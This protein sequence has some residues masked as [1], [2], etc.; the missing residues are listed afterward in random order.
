MASSALV[1]VV[2]VG[3]FAEKSRVLWCTSFG[4]FNEMCA[5]NIC[6]SAYV[7]APFWVPYRRCVLWPSV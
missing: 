3:G 4:A 7:D 1:G 6:V 2:W 5:L